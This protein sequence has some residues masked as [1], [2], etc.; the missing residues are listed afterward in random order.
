MEKK[1]IKWVDV[2]KKNIYI[3]KKPYWLN[4]IKMILQKKYDGC[5]LR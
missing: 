4:Q 1:P 5:Q 3:I 2:F